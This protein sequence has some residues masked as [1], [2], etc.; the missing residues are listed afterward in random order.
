MVIAGPIDAY[1][2]SLRRALRGPRSAKADLL[3]EA[4]D[5]LT[6]AA[7]HYESTGLPRL[8]A[9]RL[10]VSDFGP[11]ADL[12]PEYQR[13]LALTQARRTAVLVGTAVAAQSLVSE[14]AW[15]REATSWTWQPDHLYTL[16]ANTVDYAAYAVVAAALLAALACGIGA[17]YVTVGRTFARATGIAAISVVAFF[18]AGSILLSAFS[19]AWTSHSGAGISAWHAV[20]SALTMTLPVWMTVSGLRCVRAAAA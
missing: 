2:T 10:A 16:L 12:A 19:P 3:A 13:E 14:L 9:E 5:G 1:V 18:I 17:R 8:A 15:R 4:R 20:A 11:V 7:E 6:D